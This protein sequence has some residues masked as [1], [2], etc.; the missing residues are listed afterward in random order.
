MRRNWTTFALF[1]GLITLLAALAIL[2]YHWQSQIS[3]SQREKMHKMAQENVNRFS[4][5]FNKQIQAA[6]FNFQVGAED[7]RA[8]NIALLMNATS[9]GRARRITHR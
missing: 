9:F 1:A 3:E 8:K 7:W 5:D 2:Q 6:Y 4:E